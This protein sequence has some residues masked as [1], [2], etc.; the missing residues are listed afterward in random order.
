MGLPL[1]VLIGREKSGETKAEIIGAM[2]FF[3]GVFNFLFTLAL[4]VAKNLI[5]KKLGIDRL[6]GIDDV[7]LLTIIGACVSGLNIIFYFAFI[8]TGRSQI[9]LG[10]DVFTTAVLILGSGLAVAIFKDS[11][12]KFVGIMAV[13]LFVEALYFVSCFTLLRKNIVIKLSTLGV[14]WKKC[15]AMAAGDALNSSLKNLIPLFLTFIYIGSHTEEATAAFN[16]GFRLA[17]LMSVPISAIITTGMP[18]LASLNRA[19]ENLK[20]ERRVKFIFQVSILIGII[21]AVLIMPLAGFTAHYLFKS[22]EGVALIIIAATL[23]SCVFNALS[24]HIECQLRVYQKQGIIAKA[25]LITA[26]LVGVPLTF[27]FVKSGHDGLAAIFGYLLPSAIL[28]VWYYHMRE[29]L[30]EQRRRTRRFDIPFYLASQARIQVK[31][32]SLLVN[33]EVL[34]LSSLGCSVSWPRRKSPEVGSV[35][36]GTLW[37]ENKRQ[38]KFDATVKNFVVSKKAFWSRKKEQRIGLEFVD[39]SKEGQST[40]RG[41]LQ[42]LSLNIGRAA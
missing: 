42:N 39:L 28:T 31:E 38:F 1:L 23:L 8:A 36:N 40:L 13:N 10:L 21:L 26:Y 2:L 20:W 12:Q 29:S 33:V 32:I 9:V 15:K 19:E 34:D 18:W 4:L 5:L 6:D 16:V 30:E 41:I 35:I 37:M 27:T 14:N 25:N 22:G 24:A 11:H 3:G 7:Y 17:F